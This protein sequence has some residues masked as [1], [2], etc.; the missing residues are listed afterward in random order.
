LIITALGNEDVFGF[1]VTMVDVFVEKIGAAFGELE[2]QGYCFVFW[3]EAIFFEVIF[4][5][6][7]LGGV[8]LRDSIRGRSR[9]CFAFRRNQ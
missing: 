8:T 2:K 1:E 4:E 6:A 5:I 3:Y 9:Y 7:G